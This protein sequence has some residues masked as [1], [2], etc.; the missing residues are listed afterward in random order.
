MSDT[1]SVSSTPSGMTGAGGGNMLRITGMATGLDVDAMVKKMM[2]AEQTKLDKAKQQQQT[3]QWKQDAYQSIIK[4]IKDLQSSFFDSTSSDKN[5]LSSTTFSPFTVSGT[6]GSSADTS[7]A[8][9]I[10][11]VGAKVGTYKVSVAGLATG[12]G[13]SNTVKTSASATPANATPK[14]STKLTDIDPSLTGNIQLVLNVNGASSSTTIT[15]KN[16]GA[17]TVGDLVNAINSQSSGSVN[18]SFNELTGQFQLNTTKTGT[19]TSLSFGNGTTAG[20]TSV[21]GDYTK[22]VANG[23]T[24][25]AGSNANVTITEPNGSPVTLN[26]VQTSNNFTING[27]TYLLSSTGDVTVNVGADTQK[28]YDKIK[29]F[30]DKYNTVVDEIQTKLDEKKDYNYQPLTD[31]QKASM[32]ASDITNWETKAK[33]GILKNDD[34]LQKMLDGLRSAFTTAVNNAGFTFGTYGQ[35]SIGLDTST[36]YT[37]PAHIDI[38][39]PSKLKAAISSNA[40]QLQ[41]MFTNISDSTDTS[42]YDVNNVQYKEDGILTRVSKILQN[43]VGFTNTTLNTAILTS[44]ANKQYDFTPTGYG[45][46]NTIPDQLYEQQLMVKKITDGMNTKQELYYKQFS[47]L[48]TAM[49]TL[50]AQQAQLSSLTG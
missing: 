38:V 44:Y 13:V 18:A 23:G 2:A 4:D 1:S 41:K 7:V 31:A 42:T 10:P 11:G 28:V 15:L 8:T 34:N 6:N 37:K 33:V 17:S 29:D 19:S 30:I 3:I 9:F 49:Q 22:T 50:N 27:M 43:N 16:T 25:S 12:A 20:L 5:I 45:G 24:Y 39:D 35:N 46:K 21:L 40:V 36:D 32:S 14:L 26:G 48:E 47:Q